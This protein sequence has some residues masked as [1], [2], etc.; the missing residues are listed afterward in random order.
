VNTGKCA[1]L[2]VM[3]RDFLK[4]GGFGEA[5]GNDVAQLRRVSARSASSSAPPATRD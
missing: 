1:L 4:P 3:Q 2:I 5:L